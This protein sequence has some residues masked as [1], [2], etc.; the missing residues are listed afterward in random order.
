MNKALLVK[1]LWRFHNNQ[2]KGL[3]KNII[4]N[5][6]K[7]SRTTNN[8]SIFWKEVNKEKDIFITSISNQLGNGSKTLFWK[9]RWLNDCSLNIQYPLLFE[10]S[11]DPNITVA[12]V[13]GYNRY[14]LSFTSSLTDTLRKQLLELYTKLS[15]IS[16]NT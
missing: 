12:R 13:I 11:M 7:N 9:D 5:R 6:Y 3:W 2:E 15:T 1:W 10:I 16:L 14:Y 4:E 8:M